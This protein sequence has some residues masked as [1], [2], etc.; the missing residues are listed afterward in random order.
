MV[1]GAGDKH[2]AFATGVWLLLPLP[3]PLQG[4]EGV[5]LGFWSKSS[6]DV[7]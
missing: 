4:D 2:G 5:L 7:K 3:E 1:C 6:K